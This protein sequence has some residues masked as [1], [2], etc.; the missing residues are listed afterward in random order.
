MGAA[1]PFARTGPGG[2]TGSVNLSTL[3]SGTSVNITFLNSG[4][5]GA[6]QGGALLERVYQLIIVASRV[7]VAGGFLDD[8]NSIGGDN[9]QTPTAAGKQGG[10]F[11]LYGD[12]NGDATVTGADFLAFR[13]AFLQQPANPS[14]D[15]NGDGQVNG[16][17][18]LQF[19][20]RFLQSV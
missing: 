10:I 9:Y 5:V 1:F 2:P 15:F 12:S 17:D 6:D 19:R 16:A 8:A 13:L 7:S 20:L 18:F 3:R 4:A 11:R 14:F